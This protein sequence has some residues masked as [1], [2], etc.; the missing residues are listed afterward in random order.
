M[1]R[2]KAI[3]ILKTQITCETMR[4]ACECNNDCDSCILRVSIGDFIESVNFLLSESSDKRTS[5]S[6]WLD[7][8][9]MI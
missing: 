4:I 1:N 7:G 8:D 9:G 3:T 6:K 5:Q 2:E